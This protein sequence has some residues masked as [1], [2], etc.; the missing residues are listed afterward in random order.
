MIIMYV[1]VEDLDTFFVHKTDPNPDRLKIIKFNSIFSYGWS[2]K[3][4]ES[5]R[6]VYVVIILPIEGGGR[7]M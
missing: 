7:F 2:L 6:S 3:Q 4:G 5:E 1:F